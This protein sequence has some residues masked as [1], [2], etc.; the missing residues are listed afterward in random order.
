MILSSKRLNDIHHELY[1]NGAKIRRVES[2]KLLGVIIDQTLTFKEH[3]Q[4]ITNSRLKK[5][6]PLFYYLRR[7]IP[8]EFLLNVY[9]A[10][11]HSILN[12]CAPNYYQ[13][14]QSNIKKLEKLQKRI[15]KVIF[16]SNSSEVDLHMKN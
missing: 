8:Q 11:V 6:L 2:L 12:Y 4:H 3:C 7:C 1:Y 16:K 14:N 9:Y 5:F 15:L 10:N 13:G